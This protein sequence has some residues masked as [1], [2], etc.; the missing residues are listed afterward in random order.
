M[1][2]LKNTIIDTFKLL[3]YKVQ[4]ENPKG[5]S[6]KIRAYSDVCKAFM[7]C[8]GQ[9]HTIEEIEQVLLD[10]G[11]KN[12]KKT[13]EKI[14]EIIETGTLSTVNGLAFNTHIQA[15]KYLTKV[16]GIG[17][18][19]ATKLYNEHGCFK[20]DQLKEAFLQN[21]SILNNKQK[22]GLH[23]FDDLEKK[24][25]RREIDAYKQVLHDIV[26]EMKRTIPS[27][28]FSINGSYRREKSES[29]DIDILITAKGDTSSIRKQF[30]DILKDKN[31][32]VETLANG[33]KKFMGISKLPHY[34]THRHIDIIDT[35]LHEYPFAQLY[36]TGS[37]GFNAKMRNLALKKGYSLNEYRISYK[38]NKKPVDETEFMTKLGQFYCKTEKDIF[39]FLDIDYVEPKDRKDIILSK[40]I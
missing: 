35:S 36:F 25:P 24:I 9:V 12:P 26:H 39:R 7:L 29:G 17:P 27:I 20:V 14:K 4:R 28:H 32:I 8:D 33:K 21:P 23:Y 31:I 30:I 13:L 11:M 5:A 1:V 16:Y 22:I 34:S 38:T 15:L 18:K 6:F 3:I 19:N 40:Y 2:H 37:G 10:Y